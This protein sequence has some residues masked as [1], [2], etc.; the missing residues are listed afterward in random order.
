MKSILNTQRSRQR[1]RPGFT[2]I[3]ILVVVI[4]IALLATVA[5]VKIGDHITK[6][7]IATTEL[8][9]KVLKTAVRLYEMQ[10]G[11]YPASLDELVI[12]GDKDWPGPFI[13]EE[14]LPKDG[15]E[16]DFHYEIKGK[17]VRITSA[18]PDGKMG[19]DDDI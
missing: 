2:L 6:T 18:G 13:E 11:K 7:K 3:E 10:L 14:E 4:I 1:Q 8:N 17:R 16:N 12:E 9:I 15:W 19:T 5:T